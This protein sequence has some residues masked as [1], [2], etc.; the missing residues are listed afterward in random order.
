[1]ESLIRRMREFAI[2]LLS[3]Q[4]IDF[5]LRTPPRGKNVELSLQARRQVCLIFKECIHNAARHSHCTA[6]VAELIIADGEAALTIDDNGAG[7]RLEEKPSDRESHE[8]LG[9]TGIPNMRRRSQALGGRMQLISKPGEGCCV[10]IR[11]PLRRS[12]FARA[13]S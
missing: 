1:M 8:W 7:L 11:F 3:S 13:N 2:D 6:V 10:E 5:E 12:A 4:G 9:G